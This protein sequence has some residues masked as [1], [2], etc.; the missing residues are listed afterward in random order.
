MDF[1][2]LDVTL[3]E[4]WELIEAEFGITGFGVIVKLLQRIYG[5]QGY[6]VEWTNEVALLFARKIG[7]GGNVVSEIV[8][9][10][11]RRGIFDKTLYEKHSVLTSS[12][13]QKRYFKAVSRRKS[14][15]VINEYLLAEPTHF[16][17]NVNIIRKNVNISSENV[18]ISEQ[19]KVK[20]S[21]VKE[22]K[23]KYIKQKS[24][25][26]PSEHA[27]TFLPERVREI[28]DLFNG[29][30]KSLTAVSHLTIQRAERV[31][32]LLDEYSIEDF[33]TAFRKVE[34]ST[35][36]TGKDTKW[37]ASFDWLIKDGNMAKVLEGQY[38]NRSAPSSTESSF[39]TDSFF[40]DAL[41]RS[42][43]DMEGRN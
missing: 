19:S 7:V 10:A 27:K 30:C 12:G 4:K 5:G 41:K 29:T 26:V 22:S 11:I 16:L 25:D 36:L 8:S 35:F 34:L 39:D 6:Y 14:V 9:T 17:D 13:I 23:G 31:S 38:D 18:N 33:A 24:R 1:F 15:E 3:D 37:K 40:A 28:V 32:A 2:S 20:E 42:Y 43:R 21:K